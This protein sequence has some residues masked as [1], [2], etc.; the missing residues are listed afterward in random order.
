MDAKN[1]NACASNFAFRF[2]FSVLISKCDRRVRSE[3]G[4]G[5]VL[6]CGKASCRRKE[7]WHPIIHRVKSPPIVAQNAC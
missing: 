2:H 7:I 3:T 1:E 5:A 4:D 6:F